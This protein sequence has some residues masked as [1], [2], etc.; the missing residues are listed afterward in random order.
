M[1]SAIPDEWAGSRLSPP[2]PDADL[3][4]ALAKTFTRGGRPANIFTLLGNHPKLMER[5][6]ALG[7]QLLRRGELPGTIREVAILRVAERTSCEYEFAQHAVIAGDEGVTAEVVEE[8]A[9]GKLGRLGPEAALACRVADCLLDEDDVDA[10]TWA[11][12]EQTWPTRARIELVVLIG[13]YR[14][15][16]GF[17]NAARVPLDPELDR[18]PGVVAPDRSG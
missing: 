5:F 13:F 7:G 2:P 11:E 14:M 12:V 18:W 3:D 10:S 8:L 15:V 6:N 17:L 1:T 9:R 4:A 16:A